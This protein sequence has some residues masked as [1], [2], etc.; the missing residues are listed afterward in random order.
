MTVI[1]END[2]AYQLWGSMW[3]SAA[4]SALGGITINLNLWFAS[5]IAGWKFVNLSE[6]SGFNN[7]RSPKAAENTEN[8]LA[9]AKV[10]FFRFLL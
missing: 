4:R 6:M 5:T 7:Q 10:I 2:V 9:Q 3:G 1:K 8:K